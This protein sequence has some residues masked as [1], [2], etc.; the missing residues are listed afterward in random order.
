[1]TMPLL[2]DTSF[3]ESK[4]MGPK[5]AKELNQKNLLLVTQALEGIEYFAFFGALLGLVRDG[6]LIDG[7][8]D[9]DFYV[10]ANERETVIELMRNNGFS[11]DLDHAIN[12]YPEFLQAHRV[13]DGVRTIVDF[14]F[15]ENETD[16]DY[17]CEKWNFIATPDN[18]KT[19]MHVPKSMLFPIQQKRFLEHNINLPAEPE[20]A[21]RFLYGEQWMVKLEKRAGYRILM[22]NNKPRVFVGLGGKLAFLIAKIFN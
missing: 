20:A 6:D 1:M 19:H 5:V 4:S 14:Y 7:D 18:A 10:N 8:D 15:Y 3:N 22:L 16:K 17:V 13:Q 11:V 12:R 21:C 2:L 9:I